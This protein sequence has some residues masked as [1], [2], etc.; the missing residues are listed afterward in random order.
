MSNPKFIE[1]YDF[2]STSPTPVSTYLPLKRI[3]DLSLIIVFSPLVI[4]LMLITAL[5]IKLESK[6]SVFFWQKRVGLNGK[7][8]NMLKFRSMVE[9]SEK[10]GLQFAKHGDKRVTRFGRFIRNKRI[11]EIPQLWNIIQGEMSIIGPRPEQEIFVQEYMKTIP[12]YSSRHKVRPGI[13]GLAQVEQGYVD[14]ENGTR[15]KLIYDLHYIKNISFKMDI[16]IIVKTIY[17]VTTGF[18]SR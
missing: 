18:G 3:I 11:D 10:N 15:T 5:I 14:D 1:S 7:V 2:N 16:E 9:D 17:T 4:P 13:T 12:H 8:F 6:G